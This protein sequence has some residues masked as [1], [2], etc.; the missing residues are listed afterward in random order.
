[1]QAGRLGGRSHERQGSR[2]RRAGDRTRHSRGRDRS[3]LRVSLSL[4]PGVVRRARST[5]CTSL[6]SVSS[7]S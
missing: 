7:P 3:F 2:P 4:Q 6:K 5:S 1:M